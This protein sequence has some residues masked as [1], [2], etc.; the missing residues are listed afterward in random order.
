PD[1]QTPVGVRDRALFAVL[2]Y[3]GCRVGELTR[4]RVGDYKTTGAHRIL[5]IRGKGGKER[6]VP[7]HAEAVE[8]LEAWL[9]VLQRRN[10]SGAAFFPPQRTARGRGV[11]GF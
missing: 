1:P 2:A 7:L 8:R 11:D 4:L 9:D 5:E 10:D 6:R 3:T